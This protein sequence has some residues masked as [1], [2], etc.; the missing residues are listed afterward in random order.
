MLLF[1]GAGAS[2][3]VGIGDLEDLS[4]KVNKELETEGYGDVLNNIINVLD[5]ANKEGQFLNEGEID[6]EVT[7]SILNARANHIN[8]LKKSGPYSI[9]LA[10]LGRILSNHNINS[11][12][13]NINIAEIKKVVSRI[14]TQSCIE[15]DKSKATKYYGDLFSLKN[16]ITTYRNATQLRSEII[17]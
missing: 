3:A 9:Y 16:D 5:R 10:E 2:K 6:I 12:P 11:F 17:T 15:Y 7:L 13:I 4:K 14:I 1:L 8:A